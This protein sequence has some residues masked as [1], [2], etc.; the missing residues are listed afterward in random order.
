MSW[1]CRLET[2]DTSKCYWYC[3]PQVDGHHGVMAWY[4]GGLFAVPD[5]KRLMT[6]RGHGGEISII[7]GIFE[8]DCQSQTARR[9]RV[10]DLRDLSTVHVPQVL[11]Y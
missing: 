11:R 9:M 7:V 5:V 6:K 2:Y 1:G 10:W 3:L 4:T 8:S